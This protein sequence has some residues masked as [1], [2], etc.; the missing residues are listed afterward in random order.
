MV[1]PTPMP[2]H[3]LAA[4]RIS[5]AAVLR[6]SVG[7]DSPWNEGQTRPTPRS[8]DCESSCPRPALTRGG[9]RSQHKASPGAT[10]DPWGV[11]SL[12]IKPPAFPSFRWMILGGLLLGSHRSCLPEGIHPVAH[13]SNLHV[14]V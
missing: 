11:C 5:A 2:R 8:C 13:R 7:T 6:F 3:I 14:Y 12:W 9:T 10:P 1:A 4:T